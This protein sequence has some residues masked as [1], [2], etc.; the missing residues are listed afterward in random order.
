MTVKTFFT[1]VVGVTDEGGSDWKIDSPKTVKRAIEY[2]NWGSKYRDWRPNTRDQNYYLL[3][4]VF[5]EF[6]KI[7]DQTEL[8]AL[9]N[10]K[11]QATKIYDWFVEVIHRIKQ[12]SDSDDSAYQYLRGIQRYFEWL[13]RRHLIEFNPVAGIEKE[14]NWDRNSDGSEPLT[15][16]QVGKLWNAASDLVDYL[17]IIGYVIWG[18]RRK[19]LPSIHKSQ[20]SFEDGLYIEFEE[21]DRKTG[22]ATVQALFGEQYIEEQLERL[23]TKS[24]WNGHYLPDPDDSSKPM[25][26]RKAAKRFKTLCQSE[27]VLI[28]DDPATP[29]NGR[30]T[31]HDFHAQAHV[32]LKEAAEEY[33]EEQGYEDTEAPL[34]YQ[35]KQTKEQVRQMLFLDKFK[36]VLP[37]NAYKEDLD[38]LRDLREIYGLD[39]WSNQS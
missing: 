12:Q 15:P 32:F 2:L 34:R 6:T 23:E 4:R 9:A 17:I 27:D 19:E 33:S 13:K 8:I 28:D 18:V 24:N 35:G 5:K 25:E 37:E 7:S 39:K 10:D 38:F 1:T 14:F 30:A 36:R 16:A 11:S 29:N 26:P 22:A 3:N 31:W 20:F 21:Q